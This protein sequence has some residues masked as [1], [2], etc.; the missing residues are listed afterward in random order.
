MTLAYQGISIFDLPQTD[1][2][3]ERRR[4]LFNTYI[5]RMFNRRSHKALYSK[6]QTKR[7]MIWLSQRL[8]QQSQTVF[9]IERIQPNWLEDSHQKWI[10]VLSI[11]LIGGLILTI[12]FSY[13]N[14]SLFGIDAGLVSSTFNGT[15][16]GLISALFFGLKSNQIETV[17]MVRS[18]IPNSKSN[19]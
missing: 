18:A 2:I 17:E 4:H 1:S 13:L 11:G 19:K 7:W 9:L 6:S 8:V 3:E 15:L 12:S 16:G 14:V 5:E 10:Y